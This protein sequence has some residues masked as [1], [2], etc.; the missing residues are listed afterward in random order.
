MEISW[1]YVNMIRC[2]AV[3]KL[4]DMELLGRYVVPITNLQAHVEGNGLGA[5]SWRAKMHGELVEM[6][7]SVTNTDLY[8]TLLACC[9]N[10]LPAEI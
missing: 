4:S 7:G 5:I 1:C 2:C 8:T 10:L 3:A 9:I 6:H